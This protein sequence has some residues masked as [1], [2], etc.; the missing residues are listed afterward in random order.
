[1]GDTLS[2]RPSQISHQE[3]LPTVNNRQ[4]AK[5]IH[6]DSI[7]SFNVNEDKLLKKLRPDL[8][9]TFGIPKLNPPS[10]L[11][12]EDEN[13]AIDS[14]LEKAIYARKNDYRDSL[15]DSYNQTIK[16]IRHK[17]LQQK[18]LHESRDQ[19]LKEL[20]DRANTSEILTWLQGG[21]GVA[22]LG[23]GILAFAVVIFTGGMGVFGVLGAIAGGASGVLQ[24]SNGLLS[25]RTHEIKG[26][27]DELKTM[28]EIEHG[29]VSSLLASASNT[30]VKMH[31]HNDLCAKD[32]R[33][34]FG[35]K[36]F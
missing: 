35:V 29:K 33:N 12:T 20:E 3:A 36:I 1:M 26:L 2:I 27:A 32:E 18:R 15:N 9:P 34:R 13:F 4:Q 11:I 28:G 14:N 8:A 19:L 7:A 17:Q 16:E 31:N 10:H 21:A 30:V 25:L 6:F 24:G 23:I 5:K 22:M